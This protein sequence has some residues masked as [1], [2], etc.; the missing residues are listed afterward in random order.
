MQYVAMLARAEANT[1]KA[2]AY[3]LTLVLPQVRLIA[4]SV[5]KG[6]ALQAFAS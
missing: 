4:A 2:A 1:P 5:W 3:L 6:R